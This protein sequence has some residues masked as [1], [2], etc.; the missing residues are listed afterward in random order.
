MDPITTL[1]TIMLSTHIYTGQIIGMM[2]YEHL[3]SKTHCL[4]GGAVWVVKSSS[5]QIGPCFPI[6]YTVYARQRVG[7][8]VYKEAGLCK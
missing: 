7:D 2:D 5:G 6:S 8:F 4:I 3:C 1:L